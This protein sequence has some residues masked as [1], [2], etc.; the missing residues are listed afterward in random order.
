MNYTYLLECADGTLYCGWTNDLSRR[1]LSVV[2]MAGLC[3]D[4]PAA[5]PAPPPPSPAIAVSSRPAGAMLAVDG[6][7][8]GVTPASIHLFPGRHVAR[9]AFPGAPAVYAEF[10]S[11]ES[12]SSAS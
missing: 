5:R 9:L 1:L 10:E 12:P 3:A 2:L 6:V 7:P 8:R 11:D 4:L